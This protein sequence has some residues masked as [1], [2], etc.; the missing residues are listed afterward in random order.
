[1]HDDNRDPCPALSLFDRG[2]SK[3]SRASAVNCEHPKNQRS[4]SF[5]IKC[6]IIRSVRGWSVIV[7]W[8]Y[9]R[10]IA[11]AGSSPDFVVVRNNDNTKVYE[12]CDR[13]KYYGTAT[14]RPWLIEEFI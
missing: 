10:T 1:V 7:G 6:L 8:G 5:V 12:R 13:M 4:Q 3:E 11:N 9:P 2:R 14:D